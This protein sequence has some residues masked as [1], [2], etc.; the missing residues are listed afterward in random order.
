MITAMLFAGGVGRRM[1]EAEMPKQ[2]LNVAGKP[3]IIRTMMHF[4]NHPAVDD[5]VIACKEDW[6]DYLNDLIAKYDIKKGELDEYMDYK[7]DRTLR[8]I[9]EKYYDKDEEI[10]K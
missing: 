10:N 5:I 3:I 9:D 4:E 1:K 6:I 2:F 7:I 8:R